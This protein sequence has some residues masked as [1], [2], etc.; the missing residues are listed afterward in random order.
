MT[1]A[2]PAAIHHDEPA[3][4]PITMF[5]PDFP[6]AYDD[7]LAHPAGLGSVPAGRHG[8]E[9]A[10]IGAASPASSPRTS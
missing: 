3:G 9:V 1:A 2:V 4:R 10:V 5:G 7:Y 8:T 6:F